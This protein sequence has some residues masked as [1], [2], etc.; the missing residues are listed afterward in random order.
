MKAN[1]GNLSPTRAYSTNRGGIY[2]VPLLQQCCVTVWEQTKLH[3]NKMKVSRIFNFPTKDGLSGWFCSHEGHA[4]K[5]IWELQFHWQ[6]QMMDPCKDL[7]LVSFTPITLWRLQLINEGAI[8]E[9]VW[10]CLWI[11]Q[12]CLPLWWAFK[13]D[14]GEQGFAK[15]MVGGGVGPLKVVEVT[16]Y[17]NISS[18]WSYPTQVV[19]TLVTLQLSMTFA[20]QYAVA[21]CGH[22]RMLKKKSEKVPLLQIT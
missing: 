11:Y 15:I 3:A 5:N 20:L 6:V 14:A 8:R 1:R 10:K 17:F 2:P 19:S 4:P 18:L 16:E 7:P 9:G 22:P 21:C 13:Y 12:F